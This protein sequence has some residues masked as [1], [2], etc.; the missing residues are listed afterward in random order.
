[1]TLKDW[2]PID[3]K[4]PCVSIGC[5]R[6]FNN[7]K[8]QRNKFKT[9]AFFKFSMGEE[10]TISKIDRVNVVVFFRDFEVCSPPH[11]SPSKYV[12]PF[13]DIIFITIIYNIINAVC[14]NRYIC[15]LLKGCYDIE[16][17][18]STST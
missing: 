17:H 2:P 9:E 18:L 15:S 10:I 3:G 16:H 7:S 12:Y 4:Y 8:G 1:M 6:Y 14:I 11:L 13:V 5:L